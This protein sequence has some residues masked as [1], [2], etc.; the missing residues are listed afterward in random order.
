MKHVSQSWTHHSAWAWRRAFSSGLRAGDVRHWRIEGGS[1]FDVTHLTFLCSVANFRQ[2][3][4]D[5]IHEESANSSIP[6]FWQYS[7]AK[8]VCT[9]KVEISQ[10]IS[11]MNHE[12]SHLVN[13]MSH[14]RFLEGS[15][16]CRN[17]SMWFRIDLHGSNKLINGTMAKA[18]SAFAISEMKSVWLSKHQKHNHIGCHDE[19]I[20]K[21]D[22]K[23]RNR[24]RCVTRRL[25]LELTVVGNVAAE[26]TSNLQIWKSTWRR[27]ARGSRLLTKNRF[28]TQSLAQANQKQL[29]VSNLT[30]LGV[31]VNSW[32][33]KQLQ[34]KLLFSCDFVYF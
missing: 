2:E 34:K 28:S 13:S 5:V 15:G 29:R 11:E 33:E 27:S 24:Q 1:W 16:K 32:A 17:N 3:T 10:L 31:A 22:N 20:K 14:R 23:Q 4:T 26:K 7:P 30:L 18:F 19:A 21:E 6:V 9:F 8:T 25:R 12:L